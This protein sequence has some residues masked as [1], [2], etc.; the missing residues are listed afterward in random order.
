MGISG[1][2]FIITVFQFSCKWTVGLQSKTD[3]G[4]TALFGFQPD[5][6]AVSFN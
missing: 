1:N 6:T 5:V 3:S 2:L 4:T